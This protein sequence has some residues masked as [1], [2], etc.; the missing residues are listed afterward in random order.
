MWRMALCGL[1]EFL[2][3]SLAN[4][5]RSRYEL[6]CQGSELM[7]GLAKVC[8]DKKGTGKWNMPDLIGN[9]LDITGTCMIANNQVNLHTILNRLEREKLLIFDPLRTP[10]IEME[11]ENCM[12]PLMLFI[13]RILE[14]FEV[15]DTIHPFLQQI[16]NA[17]TLD[18]NAMSISKMQEILSKSK[19]YDAENSEDINIWGEEYE[20]IIN[21]M[22]Q[23]NDKF[24]HRPSMKTSLRVAA[25]VVHNEFDSK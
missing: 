12:A 2:A 1:P 8:C 6:S 7:I 17:L 25:T 23:L 3:Y 9:Y 15:G 20:N 10:I 13:V 5:G 24:L 14:S 4:P 21:E 19:V 18:I 16:L 11:I 22:N